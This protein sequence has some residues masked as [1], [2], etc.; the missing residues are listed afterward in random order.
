MLSLRILFSN[1]RQKECGSGKEAKW[2]KNREG[3]R[4]EKL[5]SRICCMRK[6]MFSIKKKK[7]I[8][9]TVYTE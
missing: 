9:K 5:L 6:N 2:G 4:E 3:W 8:G 7:D 1:E